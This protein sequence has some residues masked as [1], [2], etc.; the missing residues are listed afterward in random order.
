MWRA[1]LVGHQHSKHGRGNE[2]DTVL[3]A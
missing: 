2:V 1:Y 3:A